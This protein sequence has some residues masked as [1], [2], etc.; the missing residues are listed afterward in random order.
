VS[1]TH[2]ATPAAA[3]RSDVPAEAARVPVGVEPAGALTS[4]RRLLCALEDA[5]PVRF[6]PRRSDGPAL[7]GVIVLGD[8]APPTAAEAAAYGVPVLALAREVA[9]P[10]LVE[11][12]DIAD[13]PALDRRLR[14]IPLGGQVAGARL[15]PVPGDEALALG[16]EGP[17]WTHTPG[18]VPVDRVAA[19]L[20]R[21]GPTEVLR[22]ALGRAPWHRRLGL[23]AVV[24]FLRAVTGQHEPRLPARATVVFDDPNLRFARYGHIDYRRLVEHADEHG[25][26]AAMAMV[27]LDA[28]AHGRAAVDLFRRRPDR[29]SL[30][31]HG[32]DHTHHELMRPRSDAQALALGAQALRRIERFERHTGLAVDRV[33]VP[34]HGVCSRA[35]A[36]ALGALRYDALCA[37]HAHPWTADPPPERTLAGWQPAE[38]VDGCAVLPRFPLSNAT[39]VALRAFIDQPVILYGHHDDLAAGLEGLAETVAGV[40]RLG[41]VRWCSLGEIAADNRQVEVDGERVGVRPW[42]GRVRITLSPEATELVVQSPSEQGDRGVTAWS[43]D[44]GAPRPFGEPL[45]LGSRTGGEAVIA[46]RSAWDTDPRTVPDPAWRPGS[47]WRRRVAEARDRAAPAAARL[48]RARPAR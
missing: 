11:Q 20:P 17:W 26:H 4:E 21:L 44:G 10:G 23:L 32:N 7:G 19:A 42:A 5:F 8:P 22:A 35:M 38:F 18:P 47:R 6:V 34:P 1:A 30:A 28:G 14:G 41:D 16:A 24:R 46:L 48:S 27:P 36:R 25:Y 2:T 12:L 15:H 43:L 37:I 29:L 13:E 31:M 39:E 40:N 3:S 9:R 33:M 45:E